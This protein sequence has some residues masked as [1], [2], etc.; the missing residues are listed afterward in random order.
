MRKLL[1]FLFFVAGTVLFAQNNSIT[2][3]ALN[4]IRQSYDKN[5]PATRALTNALSNNDI[6]KIAL[7]RENLS[8]V[9]HNFKYKV[10]VKGITNQKKSGRCWMFT[11]MNVLRPMVIDKYKLSNFEFSQNYLY[12]WDI[13][14]KA[15]LYL[16]AQIKYATKPMDDKYVDWLFKSPVGDGGVWNSFTNLA[17][18]YGLVPKEVF[19]ESNSSENTG[20]MIR[21]INRKLREDGLAIRKMALTKIAAQ[22]LQ[23]KKNK[24]LGEIYRIL[25]MNLGEPPT[26]FKYRFV[27]KDGNIGEYKTY[28]P[29]SFM[30]E[31]LGDIDFNNY[32]MLMND[33]TREYYKMY[34]IEYDRNVMEGRNWV[35]LNLPNDELKKFAIASIKGNTPM[36]ASCDVGKQLNNTIGF[37]DIDNYDFEDLYGIDFGM[38]KADRIKTHESGSTH[39]MALIAVDTDEN[40]NPV[41]WQFEN[42]WGTK[43]GH[44]GYLTFTDEWFN[45]YMF[46]VVVLKKYLDEK[47]LKLLDQKPI[48][49]PPW[50]PMFK[51]DD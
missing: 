23:Q 3:E 45:E 25:A 44:N 33:P 34:E 1:T 35:Y 16:E 2:E 31:V 48:M 28:T 18:K 50:D 37:A 43:S 49:L 29:K 40:D 17:E 19:P 27:D 8:T 46:R 38:S 42:S 47:T 20:W 6:T 32:V 21:L 9:D 51:A 11:S 13:L 30:K 26:E 12:F 15:N 39:G 5:D 36:Y 10:E 22:K 14:E 24:M 7:D 41:K 4:H